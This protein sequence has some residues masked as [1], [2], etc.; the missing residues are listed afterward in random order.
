MGFNFMFNIFPILFMLVFILIFGTIVA[1]MIKNISKWKKNMNSPR[2]TVPATVV[3]KRSDVQFYHHNTNNN[4]HHTTRSTNYFVTF[5]VESGDRM[6][7]NM[8]GNEYGL[9]IEGDH[10]NLTFQG[11][12]YISFERN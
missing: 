9:L 10:G 2:I 8:D 6:E 11:T 12:K 4:M 3:S 5:Q 7:L 1:T